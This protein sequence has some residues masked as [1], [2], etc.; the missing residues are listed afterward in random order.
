MN[1]ITIWQISGNNVETFL[2]GQISADVT[3]KNPAFCYSNRQ[4]KVGAIGWVCKKDDQFYLCLPEN[5]AKE[6]FKT[7]QPYAQFSNI[8]ANKVSTLEPIYTGKKLID[9]QQYKAKLDWAT[10]ALQYQIPIL[11]SST[12]WQYTPHML[13]LESWAVNFKKGCYLGQEII[14][15]TQ[16]LGKVKRK[17]ICFAKPNNISIDAYSNIY[18]QHQQIVGEVLYMGM[19][20]IQAIVKPDN[21]YFINGSCLKILDA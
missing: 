15:R 4:G 7:W 21:T 12:R 20:I 18:D 5:C 9:I 3:E 11:T 2:Q 19:S 8:Q 13:G 1:D 10:H 16:N 6:M 14:A 17:F